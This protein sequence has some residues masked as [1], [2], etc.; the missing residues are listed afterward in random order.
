MRGGAEQNNREPDHKNHFAERLAQQYNAHEH[1]D[2]RKWIDFVDQAVIQQ[3]GSLH[4]FSPVNLWFYQLEFRSSKA[5]SF[6]FIPDFSCSTGLL[7]YN[8]LLLHSTGKNH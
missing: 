1:A 6:P 7:C 8:H 3:Y 4:F 2:K 5:I